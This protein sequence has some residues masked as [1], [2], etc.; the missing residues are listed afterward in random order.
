[1]PDNRLRDELVK[2]IR[3]AAQLAED[4]PCKDDITSL[5][6]CP[7]C[8]MPVSVSATHS[9]VI[10]TVYADVEPLVDMLLQHLQ[11]RD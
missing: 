5:S 8:S 7:S 1:M 6:G 10:T 9:G 2:L 11:A 3:D 4:T